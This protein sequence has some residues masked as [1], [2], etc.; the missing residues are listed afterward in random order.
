VGGPVRPDRPDPPTTVPFREELRVLDLIDVDDDV[1]LVR[2]ISV[3]DAARLCRMFDRL[4]PASRLGR[5]LAPV[6]RLPPALLRDFTHV[7][8]LRREALVAVVEQEI[9][10]VARYDAGTNGH[11]AEV[12]VTV[13]DRWQRRGIGR[14]LAARLG[15]VA[16]ERGIDTFVMTM[17]ADNHAALGLLHHLSP[18]AEVR[19][20]GPECEARVPVWA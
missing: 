9:V 12:A 17:L 18:I 6:H 14:R 10:A 20:S 3:T 19:C 13:E 15:V 11:E 4:S 5:F 8:H 2:T 16:A 1:L 7:D